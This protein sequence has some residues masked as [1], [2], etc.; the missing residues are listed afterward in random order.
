[1]RTDQH[2]PSVERKTALCFVVNSVIPPAAAEKSQGNIFSLRSRYVNRLNIRTDPQ[3]C[4]GG[5]TLLCWSE[6][7]GLVP[8]TYEAHGSPRNAKVSVSPE[9]GFY[10]NI[11]HGFRKMTN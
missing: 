4:L 10:Q 1:M 2:I 8:E 7:C 11:S 9:V 3:V 6:Y 5:F